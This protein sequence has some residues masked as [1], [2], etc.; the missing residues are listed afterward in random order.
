MQVN[1]PQGGSA[2]ANTNTFAVGDKV[3]Y[4]KASSSGNNYRFSAREGVI[5][6]ISVSGKVAKVKLRNGHTTTIAL[7]SLTPIGQP[8]ALTRMLMGER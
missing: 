8:N 7:S 5:T 4:V 1:Q 6:E 3:S 2:E